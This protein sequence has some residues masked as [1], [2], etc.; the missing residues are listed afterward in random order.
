MQIDVL[1]ASIFQLSKEN[2]IKLENSNI[3]LEIYLIASK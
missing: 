3:P 1:Y 2:N